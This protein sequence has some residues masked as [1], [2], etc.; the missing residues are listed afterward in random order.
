MLLTI[1]AGN[2]NTVFALIEGS[3]IVERWRISTR[4]QRTYEEYMVWLSQLMDFHGHKASDIEGAIVATVVPPVEFPLTRLCK[5]FFKVD[6]LVVGRLGCDLGVSIEID[7]PREV[8][9]DRLV[10]AVAGDGLYGGPVIIVDFGT[11]TTFDVVG[12]GGAYLGGVI[13]PG[14]NLSLHALHQAAAKL[15]HIAVEAPMTGRVTGKNTLDAMQ[16]GVFWGYVGLIEGIVTRLK[17]EHS[18]DMKVIATGG[19]ATIFGPHTDLIDTV[20]SDLTLQ[21]LRM[22]FERNQKSSI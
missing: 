16:S 12:E 22:I 6:P 11:A 20:S 7:N 8:G 21:G 13:C 3:R 18:E 9:A 1:D 15:P 4:D 5:K 17:K 14:I 19:L 2:T 10:N